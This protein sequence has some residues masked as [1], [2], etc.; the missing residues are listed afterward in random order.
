VAVAV[1]VV[2]D[3]HVVGVAAAGVI[4]VADADV[5]VLDEDRVTADVARVGVVARRRR[6]GGGGG[7]DRHTAHGDVRAAAERDVNIGEFFN[8]TPSTRTRSQ[9]PS[10]NMRGRL[11]PAVFANGHH[12]SPGRRSC[13]RR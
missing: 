7:A 13:R 1:G 9:L 2:L 6:V 8:V 10:L 5:A 11:A 3:E 12:G 4:I